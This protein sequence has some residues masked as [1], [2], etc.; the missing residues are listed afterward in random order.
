MKSQSKALALGVAAAVASIL[1]PATALATGV[2]YAITLPNDV[3]TF[4]NHSPLVLRYIATSAGSI[5]TD[6]EAKYLGHLKQ[7]AYSL[8]GKSTVLFG[9]R[10]EAADT[11]CTAN[12]HQFRLMTTVD[13]TI[14][15]GKVLTGTKPADPPGAHMGVNVHFLRT[16]YGSQVLTGVNAFAIG[17]MTLECTSETPSTA[18]AYWYCNVKAELAAGYAPFFWEFLDINLPIVLDKLP[19]NTAAAC[20]VFRDGDLFVQPDAS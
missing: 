10:C 13:G 1:S 14:I 5:N 2:C 3:Q 18:P 15:T 6:T 12:D 19:A 20:S 11:G 8:V 9:E 16:I 4:D 17:P 7:Q